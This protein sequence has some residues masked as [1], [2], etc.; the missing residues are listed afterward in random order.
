MTD[1]PRFVMSELNDA[2]NK[3][4]YNAQTRLISDSQLIDLRMKATNNP[5][6]WLLYKKEDLLNNPSEED[7]SI[8]KNYK[9][10]YNNFFNQRKIKN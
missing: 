2:R 4:K 1:D 6:D 7:F 8:Y 5:N 9:N 10:K 3:K